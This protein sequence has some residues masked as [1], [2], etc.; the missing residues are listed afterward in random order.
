MV[1]KSLLPGYEAEAEFY[2]FAWGEV[3]ADIDFYRKRLKG[4]HSIL[5]CMSGTGRIAIALA[6]AGLEVDGIDSS[7]EMI[8]RARLK[9]RSLPPSIRRRLH[10][11]VGD[12]TR[13]DM[14]KGHDAAIIGLNSY[15]LVLSP[16]NRIQGLKRI[17]RALRPGGRLF[18]ALDSVRSY[19][20]IRDGIPFFVSARQIKPNGPLYAWIMAETGSRADPVRSTTLHLVLAK[21]GKPLKSCI[22]ATTTA[23]I[24]P[25]KARSELSHAG[26]RLTRLFGDYD[27][28]PYSAAGDRFII[29]SVAR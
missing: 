4:A 21:S 28:R 10:W 1:R 12:I 25:A 13:A 29:E 16:V 15:G 17:H 27:K 22:T 24:S 8:R 5:D 6:R 18:L 19:R 9:C 11:Q 2:D 7:A 26:F 20:R 14:G 3:R 23:V